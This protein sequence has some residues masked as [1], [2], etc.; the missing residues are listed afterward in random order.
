MER[1]NWIKPLSIIF[2]IAAVLLI[3]CII[4]AS[5]RDEDIGDVS[6][7]V[8][9]SLTPVP[10][11]V[12]PGGITLT[13]APTSGLGDIVVPTGGVAI[14]SITPG[15][16]NTSESS[17]FWDLDLYYQPCEI[18][19]GSDPMFTQ[20]ELQEIYWRVGL[21]YELMLGLYEN[22]VTCIIPSGEDYTEFEE[23]CAFY[24]DAY[25]YLYINACVSITNVQSSEV[26]NVYRTFKVGYKGNVLS[27]FDVKEY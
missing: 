17:E 20:E 12:I 10:T 3:I 15:E 13:P 6:P 25:G 2:A 21:Q 9:M 22:R 27:I 24:T 19:W 11:T 5:G 14:P 23:E 4:I 16:Q 26:Q 7:T 1:D 8:S 18:T